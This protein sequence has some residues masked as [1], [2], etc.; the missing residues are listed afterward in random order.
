M[1]S[2]KDILVF[3]RPPNFDHDYSILSSNFNPTPIMGPKKRRLPLQ[4]E[5]V[6]AIS[7][8]PHP[9]ITT[10]AHAYFDGKSPIKVKAT[11]SVQSVNTSDSL[12]TET[13]TI[14]TTSVYVP[15][16]FPPLTYQSKECLQL[17]ALERLPF[18]QYPVSHFSENEWEK[19][20]KLPPVVL[21]PCVVPTKY[22]G[23]DKQQTPMPTLFHPEDEFAG[24]AFRVVLDANKYQRKRN[25]KRG[26]SVDIHDLNKYNG[27]YIVDY[28][29]LIRNDIAYLP[30]HFREY[31]DQSFSSALDPQHYSFILA[32]PA[33]LCKSPLLPHLQPRITN[34]GTITIRPRI[35]QA[36]PDNFL[37]IEATSPRTWWRRFITTLIRCS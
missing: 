5:P 34:H 23:P 16:I 13:S 7:R 37:D 26:T 17:N 27:R 2:G 21:D 22:R 29:Q 36:H 4:P 35:P 1:A 31:H 25:F 12:A 11:Q 18:A 28:C 9:A 19:R 32:V 3:P 14:T 8:Y 10:A 15:P 6:L 30:V 33:E 24:Y 20:W